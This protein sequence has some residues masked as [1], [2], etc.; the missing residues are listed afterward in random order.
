MD[1]MLKKLY[2]KDNNCA[3]KTMLNLE[4]ISETSNLLYQHYDF[5]LNMLNSE[6]A[7]VRVRGFR[8]ICSLAKWDVEK[9]IDKDIIS[10]LKALDDTDGTS[11][12]Q[13]LKNIDKLI[14]YKKS[15][16]PT[17]I[18]KLQNLNVKQYKETMQ[19]LIK[20]DVD[21]IEKRSKNL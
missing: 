17:I 18:N 3:Y 20:K 4:A 16:L 5:L 19:V 1:E 2:D 13:C 8:L 6:R 15:L 7:F 10:I 11:V 21:E 12:R 9:K 14:Y